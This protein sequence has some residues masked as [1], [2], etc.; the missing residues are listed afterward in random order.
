MRLSAADRCKEAVWNLADE[1]DAQ[2]DGDG[3]LDGHEAA[4]QGKAELVGNHVVGS[5]EHAGARHE[6]E[7]AAE[8]EHDG[9]AAVQHG[10]PAGRQD[11]EHRGE[12]RG[13]RGREARVAREDHIQDPAQHTADTAEHIVFARHAE[14]HRKG[15]RADE[16]RDDLHRHLEGEGIDRH[17]LQ[18]DH[19]AGDQAVA[20][21]G[22]HHAR[23]D[24]E[25]H[26]Q[27]VEQACGARD[28]VFIGQV[29]DTID[30]RHARNQRDDGADDHVGQAVAEADAVEEDAEARDEEAARDVA[31]NLRQVG[32]RDIEHEQPE[33]DAA[34]ERGGAVEQPAA[35]HD[36]EAGAAQ[37]GGQDLLPHGVGAH[38]ADFLQPDARLF[39]RVLAGHDVA[40]ELV[41]G[42]HLVELRA[43]EGDELHVR[44]FVGTAGGEDTVAQHEETLGFHAVMRG[45]ALHGLLDAGN[46]G[47]VLEQD[48][49]GLR[50]DGQ[51]LYLLFF[52]RHS[53]TKLRFLCH[54][55]SKKTAGTIFD[56]EG[57]VGAEPPC[58]AN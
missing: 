55:V 16:R 46:L 26:Q 35:E 12:E 54:I 25:E 36:A 27:R 40:R 3:H 45:D 49:S 37:R 30:E 31:H 52:C 47:A 33:Q 8:Q 43:L 41:H 28:V 5:P 57:D 48:V 21:E 13:G 1:D 2:D 56:K 44:V 15:R 9:R 23:R 38:R 10:E 34:D 6:R 42:H 20:H 53:V 32:R 19:R 11:Y 24:A 50:C 58:R 39:E 22:Q 14:K 29:P 4:A 51:C 7:D 18:D 17:A